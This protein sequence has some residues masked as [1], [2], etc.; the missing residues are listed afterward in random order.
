MPCLLLAV[1]SQGSLDRVA[2]AGKTESGHLMAK[3]SYSERLGVSFFFQ[4]EDGIRDLTVTGVQTCALPICPQPDRPR[5]LVSG[6]AD[7]GTPRAGP[8]R[9]CTHR[10]LAWPCRQATKGSRCLDRCLG[11]SDR[12]SVV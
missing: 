3:C 4:A 7:G 8:S 1:V 9:R 5:S 12:K 10:R 2:P 11:A 6:I